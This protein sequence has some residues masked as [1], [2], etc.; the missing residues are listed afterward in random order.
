MDKRDFIQEPPKPTLLHLSQQQQQQQQEQQEHQERGEQQL[1]QQT[2]VDLFG[3]TPFTAVLTTATR[4][5]D[6]FASFS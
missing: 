3:A 2:N 4:A 6:P 1:E 5:N